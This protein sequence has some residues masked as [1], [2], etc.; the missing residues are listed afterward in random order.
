MMRSANPLVARDQARHVSRPGDSNTDRLAI[1]KLQTPKG[2]ISS[3]VVVQNVSKRYE[4]KRPVLIFRGVSFRGARNALMAIMGPSGSGK[5][6]PVQ[7]G[8]PGRTLAGDVQRRVSPED[9]RVLTPLLA[10]ACSSR[11][12]LASCR[13]AVSN[14]SVNQA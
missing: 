6:T 8:C 7:A 5:S 12:A 13:S 1:H 10:H 9:L 14:P 4:R 3:T 2:V 11:S